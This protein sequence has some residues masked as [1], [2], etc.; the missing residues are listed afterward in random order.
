[1]TLHEDVTYRTHVVPRTHNTFGN[2][3]FTAAGPRGAERSTILFI[4]GHQLQSI[5][6]T[7]ENTS[8]RDKLT[9]VCRDHK[10]STGR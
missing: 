9:T 5:Q 10:G 1:M 7:T 8:V 2:R 3:S 4:M 6:T